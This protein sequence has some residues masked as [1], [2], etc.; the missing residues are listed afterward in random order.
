MS[1]LITRPWGCQTT[2]E[3]SFVDY[4]FLNHI[5]HGKIYACRFIGNMGNYHAIAK[6]TTLPLINNKNS[7]YSVII[8]SVFVHIISS[9]SFI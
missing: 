5:V 3:E 4:D 6:Y 2:R 8:I 9:V 1:L 7:Y